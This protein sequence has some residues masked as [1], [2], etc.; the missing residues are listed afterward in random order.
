M[1]RFSSRVGAA[2]FAVF[3]ALCCAAA[4]EAAE[5]RGYAGKSGKNTDEGYQYVTFGRYAYEADGAEAPVLWRV[6]GKG[7][8]AED[9][10]IDAAN[11]PDRKWK[12]TPNGDPELEGAEDVYCLMTDAI[13][14]FLL[15]NETADELG[16]TALDYEDSLLYR[17][18]NGEVLERMFT[19]EERAALVFMPDRGYLAPPTRKGELFR[20]DYGFVA[21]DFTPWQARR[22]KG[23]PYALSKGLRRI[24]QGY[25]WYFTADWR[26]YGARWIVGDN[27]HISVSGVDR[28]GG[29]RPVIYV[30]ADMLEAV[31]GAGT[32]EEPLALTAKKP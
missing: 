16:G 24:K 12:K 14:D 17:T 8:P 2:L 5:L 30:Q 15:H 3:L 28:E 9:D 25:C 21:E 31:G 11:V 19:P 18:L 32:A 20:A 4:A 23:T 26:R 6:L 1:M 27:G 29:I 7:T 13:V 10:V 22:A